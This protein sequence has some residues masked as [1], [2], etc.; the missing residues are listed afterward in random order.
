MFI[1]TDAFFQGFNFDTLLALISCITGIVALFLG[2]TAYD[3]CK[4]IKNSYNNNKKFGDN[5]SDNYNKAGRDLVINNNVDAYAIAKITN[6][7]FKTSLEQAY[8]L[9]ERKT[10]EN[11]YKIID[12]AN[13]VIK[14]SRWNIASYT[15]IDWINIYFENARNISDKYMQNVWAKVLA[16][17]LKKPDSFSYKTLNVL[18]NMSSDDFKLFETMCSLEVNNFLLDS[19]FYSEYDL[20]WIDRLK[21]KEF[22]LINLEGTQYTCKMSSGENEL[23]SY[24]SS[25]VVELKN[26]SDKDVDY[27]LSIKPF[28]ISAI[29]LCQVAQKSVNYNYI[30]DFVKELKKQKPNDIQITLHKTIGKFN[31]QILYEARELLDNNEDN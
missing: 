14:E 13:K 20:K 21:L 19:D 7:N 8:S 9:F 22:G 12:E 30:V 24:N 17:E 4:K 11:L 5:G 2:G 3:N 29:E 31:K 25:Y 23:L 15:K 26:T 1:E 18:K 6:E 27:T 28:T 16:I 10:E